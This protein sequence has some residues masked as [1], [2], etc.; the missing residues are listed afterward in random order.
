[1]YQVYV[2]FSIHGTNSFIVATKEV[3]DKVI[4]D[5]SHH[6][7]IYG[8]EWKIVQSRRPNVD[9]KHVKLHWSG[10][11]N[12]KTKQPLRSPP[13]VLLRFKHLAQRGWKIDE[14]SR[15]RF[16]DTHWKRD[17]YEQATRRAELHSGR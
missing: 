6:H 16:I 13:A 10:L 14:V 7:Q 1:M 8:D 2:A 17:R 15:E 4:Y 5:L 3:S 9:P 12:K 11:L